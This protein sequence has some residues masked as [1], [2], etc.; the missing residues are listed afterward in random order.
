ME[1]A[2]ANLGRRSARRFDGELR[3]KLL[4]RR[5]VASWRPSRGGWMRQPSHTDGLTRRGASFSKW[6]S[7]HLS[8]EAAQVQGITNFFNCHDR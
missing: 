5:A 4:V 8:S 3:P 1:T 6:R 7:N 2:G